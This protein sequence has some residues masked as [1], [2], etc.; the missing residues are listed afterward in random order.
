MGEQTDSAPEKPKHRQARKIHDFN[1][2]F[3]PIPLNRLDRAL[4]V[5]SAAFMLLVLI[6]TLV[7][8]SA[9]TPYVI[10]HELH[11]HIARYGIAVALVMFVLA[12]YIGLFKHA[13]V[14]PYFRRGAY[15]TIGLMLVEAAIGG[16]MYVFVGVRP[17]E[18][19]HLIYG[20]GA[21]LSL[22]FFIFV[23]V[24]AEKRPSMGS[25][26]WAFALLAGIIMRAIMTG[27]PVG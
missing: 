11:Y 23:E 20:L 21:I 16:I 4:I 13:D 15:A 22:P 12:A 24:T 10:L 3:G 9:P 27:P 17:G 19:V 7:T 8:V 2:H 5:V 1:D 14:T 6:Q 18:D 25:Y 26:L